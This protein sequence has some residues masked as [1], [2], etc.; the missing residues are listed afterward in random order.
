ML[1]FYVVLCLIHKRE[2]E[3]V[4]R[5]TAYIK[6]QVYFWYITNVSVIFTINMQTS[7]TQMRNI[8]S[9]AYKKITRCSYV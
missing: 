3:I 8:F 7:A 2:F 5:K 1:C 4:E 9:N 6:V